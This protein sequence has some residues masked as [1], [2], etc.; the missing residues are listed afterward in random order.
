MRLF[1]KPAQPAIAG[2]HHVGRAIDQQGCAGGAGCSASRVVILGYSSGWPAQA[3]GALPRSARCPPGGCARRECR[4]ARDRRRG[5]KLPR[6]GQA[7]DAHDRLAALAVGVEQR[8]AGRA[9]TDQQEHLQGIRAERPGLLGSGGLIGVVLSL[10][11]SIARWCAFESC[12]RSAMGPP[13]SSASTRP[14]IA[15]GIAKRR[16]V[17]PSC[18]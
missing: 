1:V 15:R 17:L 8:P 14:A 2:H 3:G 4:S 5:D 16:I 12:Q 18:A 7:V 9:D 6:D 11:A 10:I 13:S